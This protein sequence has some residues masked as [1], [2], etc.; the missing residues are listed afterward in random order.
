MQILVNNLPAAIKKDS[1]FEINLQSA[2]FTDSENF[3]LNIDFPL[4]IKENRAIF[5]TVIDLNGLV[6]NKFSCS[7][8]EENFEIDG[9]LKVLS[10][11]DNILSAQFIEDF[12]E[13]D[14]LPSVYLDE[15]EVGTICDVLGIQRWTQVYYNYQNQTFDSRPMVNRGFQMLKVKC[16]DKIIPHEI[17]GVNK[18]REPVL[19][20]YMWKYISLLSEQIGYKF[21]T[22]N[23]P[24]FEYILI[25][26]TWLANMTYTPGRGHDF[27]EIMPHWTI[28]QFINYLGCLYGM[29]VFVDHRKKTISFGRINGNSL[30]SHIINRNS[31]SDSISIETLDDDPDY[32]GLVGYELLMEG[33]DAKINK[34]PGLFNVDGYEKQTTMNDYIAYIEECFDSWETTSIDFLSNFYLKFTDALHSGYF[35]AILEKHEIISTFAQLFVRMGVVNQ[36][37]VEGF[38]KL[39]EIPFEPVDINREYDRYEYTTSGAPIITTEPYTEPVY[40][41]N[42]EYDIAMKDVLSDEKN[43]E[44][45]ETSDQTLDYFTLASEYKKSDDKFDKMYIAMMNSDNSGV[46]WDKIPNINKFEVFDRLIKRN[47]EY[48]YYSKYP[49]TF[50]HY[51]DINTW[52]QLNLPPI[53]T[54]RKYTVHV[55][56]NDNLDANHIYII[57]GDKYICKNVKLTITNQGISQ[58]KELELYRIID[59]TTSSSSSRRSRRISGGGSGNGSGSGSGSGSG[60][61]AE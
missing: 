50:N 61:I 20:I 34:L 21:N 33:D 57:N 49:F 58:D 19:Q 23:L 7:I 36:L 5:G 38:N 29:K 42:R 25:C 9:Y 60:D 2:Y 12:V 43:N 15:I 48:H 35:G 37:N 54:S 28:T 52:Q 22:S 51:L 16:D 53:D 47:D 45:D 27:C 3:S 4:D 10:F 46:M 11:Q 6:S 41:V 24:H 40:V 56:T 14:D 8:I 18:Y 39:E 13:G 55:I 32:R 44:L 17:R 59:E 30:S 31:L 1:S 26:N